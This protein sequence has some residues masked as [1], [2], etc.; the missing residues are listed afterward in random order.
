MYEL[1]VSD[2]PRFR[3]Q[4]VAGFHARGVR[5]VDGLTNQSKG[6]YSELITIMFLSPVGGRG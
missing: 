5:S 3:G 1:K 4:G 6:R 2:V